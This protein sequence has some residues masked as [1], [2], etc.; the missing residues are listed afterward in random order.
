MAET[1]QHTPG[2]IH[3]GVGGSLHDH[4]GAVLPSGGSAPLTYAASVGYANM[5]RL[6]AC[7]NACEAAGIAD[8]EKAV[9]A[10][11]AAC[12][13]LLAA[14]DDVGGPLAVD[15]AVAD[16]RAALTLCKP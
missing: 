9:P 13:N 16:A 7:W 14:Y 11:V 8:P 2:Q 1:E 10:L 6:A 3:V 5:V 4:K 12:Q 15:P